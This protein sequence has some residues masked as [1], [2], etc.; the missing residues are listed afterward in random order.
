MKQVWFVVLSLACGAEASPESRQSESSTEAE[1][2][3]RSGEGET[4]ETAPSAGETV[5]PNRSAGPAR[6]GFEVIPQRIHRQFVNELTIFGRH[7][8][9]GTYRGVVS[10]FD[11]PSGHVRAARRL[12][13]GPVVHLE[14]SADRKR[15][16][17]LGSSSGEDSEPTDA[18]VW[19]LEVDRV[20][21]V[22]HHG[23][24]VVRAF[25]LNGER[26]A[27]VAETDG[28]IEVHLD[29][30]LGGSRRRRL[31]LREPR[32]IFFTRD[33]RAL[34]LVTADTVQ[35]LGLPGLRPVGEGWE[36][37]DGGHVIP[38]PSEDLVA[39]K[40]GNTVQV[41]AL[42]DG[43]VKHELD[44]GQ[45]IGTMQWSDDGSRLLTCSRQGARVFGGEEYAE[46]IDLPVGTARCYRL[47]VDLRSETPATILTRNDELMYAPATEGAEP[48]ALEPRLNEGV[49]AFP[50]RGEWFLYGSN[51]DVY[52]A[53]LTRRRARA[54]VHGGAGEYSAWSVDGAGSV[55]TLRGRGW[56]HA[57]G[58]AEDEAA[59]ASTDTADTELVFPDLE[60]DP[61]VEDL[62]VSSDRR[63]RVVVV[64]PTVEDGLYL[65]TAGAT[66]AV[67]LPGAERLGIECGL[68]YDE[69]YGEET[70]FCEGYA[71]FAAD[72]S[73]LVVGGSEGTAAYDLRGRRLGSAPPVTWVRPTPDGS[74]ML[75]LFDDGALSMLGPNLRRTGVVLRARAGMRSTV[76]FNEAGTLLA[77]VRGAALVIYDVAANARKHLINLPSR[78][79]TSPVF[80]DDGLVQVQLD[81]GFVWYSIDDGNEA[82]KVELDEV[83]GINA[84]R[85]HVVYCNDDRLR[86]RQ[87]DSQDAGIDLG[88]CPYDA[89]ELA[90]DETRVWWVEGSRGHVVRLT[91]AEH[92]LVGVY[93]LRRPLLYAF[94]PRGHFWTNRPDAVR[95]LRV[96]MRG[97]VLAADNPAPEASWVRESLIADFLADRD[98]GDAPER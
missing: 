11:V 85:T 76:G 42:A 98:L 69:E 5:R 20:W 60:D 46:V 90:F 2:T 97:P 35:R 70:Y 9:A 8:A 22:P 49:V 26:V 51:T 32:S 4:A 79:T 45:P 84:E 83:R 41:R 40:Y 48:L 88:P 53:N 95:S 63:H 94:T 38:H 30:V 43:E 67:A 12:F 93:Q 31:D 82:R 96:R 87:L 7:A 1:T 14:A 81:D 57:F 33:S 54:L 18:V 74:G 89:R 75:A 34:Y 50:Q 16:F 86:H 78:S 44:V 77:A 59:E 56:S 21:P 24:G 52:I 39:V 19:D 3:M 25:E 80:T 17:A 13:F 23:Y 15:I 65:L 37:T 64:E 47:T 28:G 68:G 62:G 36:L 10:V 29:T 55:I 66:R 91:D 6:A 73:S 71:S 61:Y 72:S 58:E 27:T 92:L